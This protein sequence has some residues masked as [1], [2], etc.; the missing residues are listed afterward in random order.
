MSSNG[1]ELLACPL[2]VTEARPCHR[3]RLRE[4]CRMQLLQLLLVDLLQATT[5]AEQAV[6]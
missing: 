6:R 2:A 1:R 4:Q 5:I 3:H